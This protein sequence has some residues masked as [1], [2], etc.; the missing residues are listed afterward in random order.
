[1]R[2]DKREYARKQALE[3]IEGHRIAKEAKP[4]FWCG[5]G[6]LVGL[7]AL[8]TRRLIKVD[9]AAAGGDPNSRVP[10]VEEC[11]QQGTW[12]PGFIDARL[13]RVDVYEPI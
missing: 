10:G 3:H 8:E 5:P 1:M 4:I 12:G 11:G 2:G 9:F 7:Y 6:P 13:G